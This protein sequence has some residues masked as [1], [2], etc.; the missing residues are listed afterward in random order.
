MFEAIYTV[1]VTEKHIE[2]A[3]KKDKM[4]C[5]SCPL[6][7][8]LQDFFPDSEYFVSAINATCLKTGRYLMISD[9]G[10]DFIRDFDNAMCNRN[11]GKP[12]KFPE[13]CEVEFYRTKF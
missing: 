4:S 2:E 11:A 10:Y 3:K 13:P 8:A 12:Y 7:L 6:A 5:S 1:P 9:I